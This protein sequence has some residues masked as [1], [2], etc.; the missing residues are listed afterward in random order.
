MFRPKVPC[1]EA[2][3]DEF[4]RTLPQFDF[5]WGD[6]WI[7]GMS[8]DP[9]RLAEYREI[10]R[11]RATCLETGASVRDSVQMKN[12]TR[13]LAKLSEH[14]QGEQ[15]EEWNP[16]Y[17]HSGLG[18]DHTS[19]SNRDFQKIHNPTMN[20]FEFG[21][22]SWIESRIFNTLAIGSAP[23]PLRDDV[24]SRLARIQ[25][26]EQTSRPVLMDLLKPHSRAHRTGYSVVP[27]QWQS[28]HSQA[29]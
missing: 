19:W 28:T 7:T 2:L 20:I 18:L 17:K 5:E 15:N 4:V 26:S 25:A 12:M 10:L 29:R 16:G 23:P 27:V 22:L 6:V 11:A 13:Y 14:T 1:L 24:I 9:R 3:N 21:E 8:T